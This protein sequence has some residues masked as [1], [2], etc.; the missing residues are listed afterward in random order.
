MFIRKDAWVVLDYVLYDE[1]GDVLEATDDEEGRPLGFVWGYGFMVPGLERALEGMSAGETK[2]LVIPPEEG[3]GARDE[4]LEH[5]VDRADF[6]EG[7]EIDDEF[8]A[9]SDAGEEITLRVV[10]IEDDAVLVDANHPLAGETL[11]FEVMVRS[12]RPATAAELASARAVAPRKKLAVLSSAA[13]SAGSPPSGGP[14]KHEESRSGGT[15]PPA[16]G[17][18]KER[19]RERDPG[20]LPKELDD[21]Q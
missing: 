21:E 17:L 9:E 1:D 11:R 13:S 6:P 3:Y 4:A 20:P 8:A 5:W 10:E 18:R 12:V 15:H 7:L 2:E 19:R 16:K 14:P